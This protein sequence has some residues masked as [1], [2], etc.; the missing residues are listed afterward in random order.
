MR[1]LLAL[2]LALLS[3]SEG[4]MAEPLPRNSLLQYQYGIDVEECNVIL[5]DGRMIQ[6]DNVFANEGE[7]V[8]LRPVVILGLSTQG[9][10]SFHTLVAISYYNE[11]FLAKVV[12]FE[13]N[14]TYFALGGDFLNRYWGSDGVFA[15]H[16]IG[17]SSYDAMDYFHLPFDDGAARIALS[18]GKT[19]YDHAMSVD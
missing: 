8:S 7:R 1:V 11:E 19:C 4:I 9:R 3:V 14:R 17:V 15:I 13:E 5:S 10:Y 2:S 18:R 6:F 12:H 16:Q